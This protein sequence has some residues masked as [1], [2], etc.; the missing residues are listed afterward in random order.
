MEISVRTA[1][2]K[3]RA[4]SSLHAVKLSTHCPQLDLIELALKGKQM[5]FDKVIGIIDEIVAIQE[6]ADRYDN[7]NV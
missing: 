1:S 7:K 3:Q 5:G 2:I 6:G 4:W